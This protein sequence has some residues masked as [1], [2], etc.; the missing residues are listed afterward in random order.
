ML[1][2]S[3]WLLVRSPA[4]ISNSKAGGERVWH[5]RLRAGGLRDRASVGQ[6]KS[7]FVRAW[8]LTTT[9]GAPPDLQFF[10]FSFLKEA[11]IPRHSHVLHVAATV[12][13]AIAKNKTKQNNKRPWKIDL[14]ASSRCPRASMLPMHQGFLFSATDGPQIHHTILG[15]YVSPLGSA[16]Q[17][18]FFERET[19]AYTEGK[20]S[21]WNT[22]VN[23]ATRSF[24]LPR[25]KKLT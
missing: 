13:L 10:F 7:A 6:N 11:K 14:G 25:K 20:Q 16:A 4:H 2:V 22:S 8:L 18:F 15:K 1:Q 12:G 21:V 23:L 17:S 5:G 24:L 9:A 3:L 19:S